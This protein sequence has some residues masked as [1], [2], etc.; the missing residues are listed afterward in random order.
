MEASNIERKGAIRFN[1][2]KY[3][4]LWQATEDFNK[5]P[6]ADTSPT[7]T[8]DKLL[9]LSRQQQVA[10]AKERQMALSTMGFS[11]EAT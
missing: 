7:N 11:A 5:G 6:Y 8:T 10:S 2:S 1:S 4:S 3:V 9:V